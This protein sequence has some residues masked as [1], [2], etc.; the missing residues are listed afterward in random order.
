MSTYRVTARRT[1]DWWA[2]EVPELPGVYSQSKRLDAASDAA[3]E[4]IAAM[5]DTE[6]D[7]I[8][9]HI[10]PDLDQETHEAIQAARR[11][12]E[13]AEAAQDAERDAMRSAA[14][15]ITRRLSQRDAGELLGV[16]FQRVSQLLQP[17]LAQHSRRGAK[18]RRKSAA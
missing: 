16:S 13:A 17:T 14:S 5:L 15:T 9:V 11:A 4:A 12:R 6:P 10:E 3:R 2:L 18:R 1:G 7:S 8:E